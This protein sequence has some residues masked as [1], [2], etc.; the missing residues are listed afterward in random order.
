MK[1]EEKV[2]PK[3]LII[4]QTFN[5][6]SG[7]GITISNL[8]Y[9]WPK[10]RIA[11]AS[12]VNL[13]SDLDLSVC[14]QYYQLGYNGKLH[15]F[16][17]NLFLPKIKCGSLTIKNSNNSGTEQGE[18][19]ISGKYKKIY[20][21]ISALLKFLGI[22]NLFYK[23][24]ITPDFEEWVKTYN[25]DVIYSQLSTLELIRFV[26][27]M[28]KKFDKPIALHI[29]DDWPVS[30]NKPSRLYSYWKHKIDREFRELL[31]KSPI[32]MSICQA[33]SDEYQVRYNK[34]FI[35]FHNPIS[36]NNWLPCSKTHWEIEGVFKILYTGRIGKANGKAILFMAKII[37]T[38]NSEEIRIK[39]DIFTPDYNS[40]NAASINSL[41]GVQV[42]NT[43]P[44]EKMPGLLASHDLLFLP[45]DFDTIGIRFAQFS[46]PTK[47]SEYMI[48][49]TPILVYADKR[50][51]LAKYALK[52][53][54]A[55]VVTENNE[56]V[57]RQA[58]NELYAD[59]SLRNELAETAMKIAIQNEDALVIR[60]KFRKAFILQSETKKQYNEFPKILIIG[61]TF[62]KNSGGGITISN[63]F[64]GWPK[65]RLAVASNANLYFDLDNSVCEHYY[66]LG[67]NSKLHPFPLNLLL[68]KIKTGSFIL[69]NKLDI[70]AER[71]NNVVT[72]RYKKMYKFISGFLT[73]FGIYNILY[74]LK[75]TPEFK[76]WVT[77]YDPDI[78]YSQLST[79]ELIRFVADL[80]DQFKKPVVLHIMDDW[81]NAIHK[82][83]MF[84]SYWNKVIDREFRKLL[85]KA[86]VLMSICDSMSEEYKIRYNKDFIP[87]HNPI[88]IE[89]WL[90]YAKNDWTVKGTYTILY[91]GR[92]GRG[93]KN[94][95]YDLSRAV[96]NFSKKNDNILFEILTNNFFEIEK[97]VELN[98]HVKW[99]KPIEYSE[100]PRKFSSVDLLILPE[101]FDPASIEFLKYSIQTKVPE[102][103]IS[104]CPILVYADN[105]TA[106]AMYAIREGWAYIVS[107]NDEALLTGALEELYT[108]LTLRKA[109][110][111]RARI[112]AIQNEDAKKVRE[113]FR[114]KL[115]LN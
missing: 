108:N 55:Y 34:I 89:N 18:S 62:N 111:E 100:L 32:L 61:Q 69:K 54:W 96:N 31:N 1:M 56:L 82:P 94:S 8:F 57:L 38:M 115:L 112:V 107:E 86:S 3:I 59:L 42:T 93:I 98:K 30:I 58:L 53:K 85:D 90:P 113:E 9:G 25:P 63:L 77:N 50:T 78:L 36:I 103:M 14:E 76:E 92:I 105:R 15:P 47:A 104:G 70:E 28:Q 39:L 74:R 2:Y 75:I 12:N 80:H 40:K 24:K 102:Y 13:Y 27:E 22:Y 60:E 79:L 73:Y 29:M 84:F 21:I 81:P 11:V 35:P 19:A 41:R 17:L 48:S 52:D 23:L 83:E 26:T 67:Y 114:K 43:V 37:D 46:M 106:L 109:L 99:L 97:L 68:P 45:L 110:A 51:A 95:I 4:G 101:D 64:Q 33:M 6:N 87:F 72:G 5:K 44:H 49:G 65:S 91:A 88:E 16:P 66:Q 7:G 10:D 71:V 20:I